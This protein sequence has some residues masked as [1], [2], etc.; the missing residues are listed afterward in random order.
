MKS[1]MPAG[2]SALLR[3]TPSALIVPFVIDGHDRLMKYGAFPLRTFQRITYT[4][5][6][7]IEPADF[8]DMEIVKIVENRIREVLEKSPA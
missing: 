7:P 4:I 6:D 5:L 2:I 3:A 8:P 1:F